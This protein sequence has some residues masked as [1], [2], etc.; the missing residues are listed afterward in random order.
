MTTE[1]RVRSKSLR[2]T[3][4]RPG[5]AGTAARSLL[6]AALA[7]GLALP[8]RAQNP[9]LPPPSQAASALQQAVQQNPNLADMIRQRISQSGMTPDQIRARLQAS[10]Y[11]PTLLDAYLSAQTPGQPAP[12]PGAQEL[13]AIQS[14]GVPSVA[15]AG[16]I[17]PV[18]TGLVRA[19]AAGKSGV[20]GVDVFQRTTT[21]FLP[22]LAGP[23]P[24]D[25]KLGPGDQLVLILTGD[26]ELAYTLQVTREGFILIPQ[27][28]QLFVSNL[29]LDQLR[30]LLYTR[31][32]RVYSGVRRTPTA[33]T[34][35]DIS[36]ANV[37]ANQVYVVGEVAQPG[38]YQISS[39]G[40]V[41]TALYAS[42]GVTERANLRAVEVRRFGK[43]VAT[44][45]LYEYL[46]RGDTK[47]D[48]RLETGDVVFVAVHGPRAQVTGA[49][50]R[51]A[52]YEMKAGGS[53]ADL[54]R[55][56][57][58][59]R[60]D[61]QLKR[62][63]VFRLLSPAERG[64]GSPPRA[65]IDV[66]LT[67]VPPSPKSGERGAIP[68]DDTHP[69]VADAGRELLPGPRSQV[70]GAV[71]IPGLSVQD[72]D[73]VVVDTVR[74][75]AGQYYVSIVGVV[76]KPG[77]YPWREGMTLRDLMLL[78]RGPGVGAD[79]NEAEVARMPSDRTQGQLA[80]TVRV[81]LDSTYLF[82][83]DSSG[84]YVGPPGLPFPAP[85]APEVA[86]QPYDNV[87]ILKQPE[88]E[89]Q[90]TVTLVGEVR[91]P[92]TYALKAKGDRLAALIQRA[93]GLTSQ[94]YADGIRFYRQVNGSGRINI[95]LPKA[96]R[97]T[98]ARDN[99][100]L[101]PGDSV[102]IPEYIPSVRVVG[103]V[104]APG[105]VL[106]KKGAGLSYYIDAAG[107]FAYTAD[108]GRTSVRSA[109]GEVETR[110]KFLFFRSDPQPGPGSEVT[111]PL[112]DTTNPTNYVALFGAIAQI[113]AST[114][115]IIVVATK[116]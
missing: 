91:Y 49:V 28:G 47:N 27:V 53:V 83:R 3:D 100:L 37:R 30:D 26:V 97:D 5:P 33:T 105:S 72:G 74:D 113:L 24:A 61:A 78:A 85:G 98:T 82:E 31:L 96:L 12:V 104:N 54:V 19:T 32:G 63:S 66:A 62:L 76:N 112:K 88:F 39:L 42:G 60:P 55:D 102:F 13:A 114:V 10:G 87:L 86:L 101:Q 92:G 65:V 23:V 75:L 4:A 11:P 84:R 90:R 103:A 34:R 94:A 71:V 116:F 109:S 48:V 18:D 41:L 45:D 68:S 115:A 107:G 1:H 106:Y 20:F 9:P 110:H 29:T 38:A 79:L 64:P 95:D 59:F 43:Q 51:P 89:L 46:L 108:P 52:V 70:V 16:E 56:A 14:L 22:L 67:P 8:A 57:G 99:L 36:V 73:S 40:T 15:T 17:L 25:Y 2:G 6:P 21:Q 93:G 7:L 44:F 69:A 58:G 35:F 80:T 50:R 77:V 81:S 111:V